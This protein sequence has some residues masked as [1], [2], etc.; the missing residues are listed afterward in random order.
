MI[1]KNRHTI[2]TGSPL[3]L[4]GI[5]LVSATRADELKFPNGDRL[6][7]TVVAVT[8][9]VVQF[10][11]PVIGSV[12]FPAENVEITRE[13]SPGAPAR[14][15]P[16]SPAAPD[17]VV[18]APAP[19]S[20]GVESPPWNGAIEF[21]FRQQ[22]GRKDAVNLDVRARA[23]RKA[24]DNVLLAEARLLHGELNN[25]VNND[26]Y[27]GSFRWRRE[28]GERT[29]AQSLTSFTRDNQRNIHQNWEQNIGAGYA[30]VK[31]DIHTVNVG[32]GLT[33]QYREAAQTEPGLHGLVEVFQDYVYKVT[34]NMTFRQN[35]A[36][37]YSPD[38]RGQF[39][40]VADQPM[41]TGDGEDNYK[42]RLNTSLQS[43]L[44]DKVSFNVRFE[45]EFDNAIFERDAR[46]DQRL[47]SS[48]GY[49]F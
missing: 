31:S 10:E 29:F 17:S 15:E 47:T 49:T 32:A 24:G 34:D 16:Q 7:G 18:P 14:T 12:S 46:T 25:V 35:A 4:L 22:D 23:E 37:Q 5:L 33:G 3:F 1:V 20:A 45:Y 40:T 44:T 11:S 30:L 38:G 19:P 41:S 2:S 36:V 26:R 43:Q 6:T 27:D 42:L 21:G 9:G 39:I 28:L 13:T 8:D 48:L